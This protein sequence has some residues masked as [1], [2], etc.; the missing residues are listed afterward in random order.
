MFGTFKKYFL[1]HIVFASM[2]MDS[3]DIVSKVRYVNFH[4][5]KIT[6]EIFFGGR[7]HVV[8]A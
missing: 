5:L 6:V 1:E 2:T 3:G 4:V 7:L 8:I